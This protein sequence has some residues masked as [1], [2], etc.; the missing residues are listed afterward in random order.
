MIVALPLTTMAQLAFNTPF[1][2]EDWDWNDDKS[3]IVDVKRSVSWSDEHGI[4]LGNNF[5]GGF[6]YSEK[7]V[8]IALST[9]GTPNEFLANTITRDAAGLNSG[10]TRV[11]F[12]VY[13]SADCSTFTEV[14]SSS[15]KKNEIAVSLP[16]DTRYIKLLYGGNFAGCFQNVMVTGT[17]VETALDHITQPQTAATKVIKNGQIYILKDNHLYDCT[18]RMVK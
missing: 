1:S 13:A 17:I 12:Q 9:N 16:A 15:D 6:D 3:T 5:S 7:Y 10:A 8:V 14:Y 18:G 2:A 4:C 11:E